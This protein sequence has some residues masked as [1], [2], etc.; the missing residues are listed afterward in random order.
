MKS[1][2]LLTALA[3]TTAL[4]GVGQANAAE[5]NVAVAANFTEAA[6]DIAA[7]FNK[8]TGDTAT[9]SFGSTG[10]LYTQISQGAPFQVFLAA[11]AERPAKAIEE[12]YGVADSNF[13]YAIGKV[14]LWSPDAAMVSGEDT[15]K[16][17][18]F[19]K[20][21]IANPTAA[22]YGAAAVETMQALGVYD[23][24]K[25]KIVEGNNIAQ[26][27]QFVDSGNAELGFV[28]LSQ[29]AGREDGSQWIVPQEDY[30]PILQDAVLLKTGED[31]DAAKAFLDFLK[32]PEAHDI[33]ENYGYATDGGN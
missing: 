8:A 4:F 3:L 18:S 17:T 20:I 33:I 29:I 23:T 10:Q 31:S 9:L 30:S 13:T 7:A 27:F 24:L 15:L 22:P 11:D 14:V 25:P 28:A 21:S 5:T 2:P 12:G 32:G 19:E 1:S 6:K 16:D 26:A